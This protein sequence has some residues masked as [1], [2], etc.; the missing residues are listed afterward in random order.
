[1][2]TATLVPLEEHLH[3]SYDPELRLQVTSTNFR[4]P[5]I[6]LLPQGHAYDGC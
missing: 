2:T 6:L 5:D 1:M 3:A 4:L